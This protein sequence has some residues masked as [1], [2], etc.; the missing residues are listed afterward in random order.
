[1]RPDGWRAIPPG[2]GRKSAALARATLRRREAPVLQST[3]G[4]KL[5]TTARQG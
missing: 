1:M 3:N 5:F 4:A 2:A